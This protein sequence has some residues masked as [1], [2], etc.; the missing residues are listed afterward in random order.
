MSTRRQIAVFLANK[1]GALARVCLAFQEAG[2]ALL[3]ISVSDAID[4]AV[5]RMVVDKP[6]EAIDILEDYGVFLLDEHILEVR[7]P[8]G[9]G[10]FVD[11]ATKLAAIDVNIDYAYGSLCGGGAGGGTLFV[12]VTDLDR[13]EEVLGECCSGCD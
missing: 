13:A 6:A 3:G 12:H 8:A 11:F 10:A 9:P 7:L 1:P 5:V 4:H 2:I